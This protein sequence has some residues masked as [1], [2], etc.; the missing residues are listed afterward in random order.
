MKEPLD[1]LQERLTEVE[2]AQV[3]DQIATQAPRAWRTAHTSP[4]WWR[5]PWVWP[6]ATGLATAALLTIVLVKQRTEVP[7]VL[8]AGESQRA[9]TDE[10]KVRMQSLP[11]MADDQSATSSRATV[12]PGDPGASA[13][14]SAE[15][16]G[17]RRD[18]DAIDAGSAVSR[19]AP[20]TPL[21]PPAQADALISESDQFASREAE[22]PPAAARGKEG[23]G[24]A[25]TPVTPSRSVA[26]AVK[27]EGGSKGIIPMA[28]TPSTAVTGTAGSVLG[29]ISG[30]VTDAQGTPLAY[31]SV[32][33]VG[34]HFGAMTD[35]AGEFQIR[36]LPPGNYA[37]TAMT[38]GYESVSV[39][40]VA[41]DHD[42]A[43]SLDASLQEK[44]VGTLAEI[45]VAA[46]REVIRKKKSET[47]HTIASKDLASLPANEISEAIGLKSGV[48][49]KGRDVQFRGGRAGEVKYQVEGIAS[50]D[51]ERRTSGGVTVGGTKTKVP[52]ASA[53]AVPPNQ[54]V[55]LHGGTA[56]PNDEK[57]DA[58]FFQHAG[59][60]PL[61]PAEEDALSTF[62][63]D[64]DNASYTL[65]RLYLQQGNLPPQEA[66]RL[67]ECVNFFRQDYPKFHDD[68]FRI[69]VDGAPAPF[70]PGYELVRVGIAARSV[71]PEDRRPADLVFVV[72][73]SGSMDREN[74]LQAVKES[75]GYLLEHLKADDRVAIVA[76]GNTAT[77]ELEPTAGSDIA[78]IRA[79][80]EG[81]RITGATNAEAGIALGYELARRMR[82]DLSWTDRW[83]RDADRRAERGARI[84]RILLCSDGVA[85]IGATG[86]ESILS[87]VREEADKGIQLSTIGFGM[88]NYNDILMERLADDG[89]GSY[90]YVD[91]L[92]E[93]KRVLAENLTGTLQTIGRD[94]KIQVEF[95]PRQVKYY[96]LLG[97]ENR[98][99][100][101]QDFRND[102]VDAGEIGAGHVVTALYE[103]KLQDGVRRGPLATVRFRYA[104]PD[105]AGTVPEVR[106][107]ARTLDVL[108]LAARFEQ[109]DPRLR[110]DAAVAEYAEILRGSFY[111]K[112]G[113]FEAILPIARDCARALSRDPEVAEFVTLVERA[114][115]LW[116]QRPSP[117]PAGAPEVERR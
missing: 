7:V 50:P 100:R 60:N 91:S 19:S 11:Y 9:V 12:P 80:I 24:P 41:V 81:L 95:D 90:Y 15:R 97:F 105:A 73:V 10:S 49:A 1:R 107:L 66:V 17:D 55:P 25:T 62:A 96:R 16:S 84:S 78:R 40:S 59:V 28:A 27:D 99:V 13:S 3:W 76:Y 67:E 39:D 70:A 65:A 87:R 72:D 20:P 22:A 18:R 54:P 44:P 89:D 64:V 113:S 117:E 75:L 4:Q 71:A 68:D 88:G 35:E 111:A 74:R 29:G 57:V 14:P 56:L 30:R 8:S 21:G 104:K 48:I 115:D 93:A 94:A 110:L 82:E 5:R 53:P 36:S 92:K 2:K 51:A 103:V 101:D 58:M 38:L 116:K 45:E 83:N 43:V 106:E 52:A 31:A 108:D 34:T 46:A 63:V 47:S 98:D 86:P 109:A 112:E 61:I 77:I 26:G 23:T 37:L 79:A 102:A 85:N 42:L 32:V 6:T 33:V 114:R 69:F